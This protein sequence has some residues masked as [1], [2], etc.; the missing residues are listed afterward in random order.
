MGIIGKLDFFIV[1]GFNDV[2]EK[3]PGP[4]DL[5]YNAH[6]VVRVDLL[7]FSFMIHIMGP[8]SK[9]LINVNLISKKFV[10]YTRLSNPRL[11]MMFTRAFT[12]L[13]AQA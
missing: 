4:R 9:V 7:A 12:G 2:V 11:V 13:M 1:G 10:G 8:I 3:V 6:G 5:L